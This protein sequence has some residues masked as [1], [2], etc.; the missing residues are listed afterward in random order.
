MDCEECQPIHTIQDLLKFDR[1][2]VSWRNLVL[3]VTPRS[4]SR[5][6]GERYQQIDF[7]SGIIDFV[8]DRTRPQV[9]L[10]HDFKGNYLADRFINGTTGEQWV[11]Y[12]FYNW[13]AIDVFCYFSHNFVT[14]P[15]LQWL[16]CAHK[17]GVR[18]I[19]TLIIEGGNSGLLKDI[20]QSEEFYRKVADALVQV[21][22]ICQFEGWLLNIETT[23]DGDK[24]PMLK[25]FVAYLT[26]KSHEQIPDSQIIWYDAI[27]EKGLLNWQNE[28]NAQNQGFFAACDGIFLNYTWNRQLL[29]RTE[30]FIANY[31]P[32]RKLDVY[33]GIDVFGRGQ[34]AKLDTNQTL[35]I[36]MEHKFSVAIFAPGWTFESLEESMRRDQLDPDACN[37]RFLKLNDRFWNLLWRYFFVR[38]PEQLPFYTSFCLGSGKLRKRLGKLKDQSW[39]NLSRQGFQPTVPYT[40]PKEFDRDHHGPNYWTHSFDT[41]LDG[42]SCLKLQE[43]HPDCRLFA[44]NFPCAGDLVVAYA[45][46]RSNENV[47][48]EL[49]L[50]AYS[51]R[52]HD[53]L[54]VV[55]GSEQC[56]VSDRNNEMKALPLDSKDFEVLSDLKVELKLPAMA[57]IN[58]WEIRYYY[59]SFE[60]IRHP[61]A[62]VDI[63]VQFHPNEPSDYVLLGAISLQAGFP[64][65]RDRIGKRTRLAFGSENEISRTLQSASK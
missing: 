62:I 9:L 21:A 6:L 36:V 17:N 10:C 37:V 22:K 65:H 18:V 34:K 48:V 31:F 25:D 12:R 52:Y 57:S 55:C 4:R 30:N 2:T 24:I 58:E 59:I 39:F 53:S 5:Y 26:K 28:L 42:G 45:F 38:G 20:L 27:T 35:G 8:D 23:L 47:D 3:P 61:M 13:A 60:L 7:N 19:G 41:A 46:Q 11:D 1:G 64:S 44:C 56:H 40:P 63:G 15:T 14:I 49:L 54:K 33:V 43:P 29:E 51:I 16:N 50:K 32:Q